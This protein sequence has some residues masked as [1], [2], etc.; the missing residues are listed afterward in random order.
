[1]NKADMITQQIFG[2]LSP[3][4]QAMLDVKFG[5]VAILPIPSDKDGAIVAIGAANVQFNNAILKPL[6]G[7][8]IVE[9]ILKNAVLNEVLK[10]I[11]LSSV[12]LRAGGGGSIVMIMPTDGG[13]YYGGLINI[14]VQVTDAVSVEA[15][16]VS[17]TL[18]LS[19]DGDHPQIWAVDYTLV[20]EGIHTI[21][22]SAVFEDGSTDTES[23][24]FDVRFWETV[25]KDGDTVSAGDVTV[26]LLAGQ[27]EILGARVNEVDMVWN[28]T[29]QLFQGVVNLVT[30]AFTLNF[31]V[32][33]DGAEQINKII[34]GTAE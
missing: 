11:L 4:L 22:V 15:K 9:V 23:A 6:A 24:T 27:D 33:I 13:I 21:E 31:D 26:E 14:K 32:A 29:R 5:D 25:P 18:T 12:E 30:G 8:P 1:M 3:E 16:T 20:D 7:L 34:G 10:G 19:Q 17:E 2:S 28:D